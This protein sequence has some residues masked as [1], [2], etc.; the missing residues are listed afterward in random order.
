MD[1]VSLPSQG[2]T[3][4]LGRPPP[5]SRS[6]AAPHGGLVSPSSNSEGTFIPEY[7]AGLNL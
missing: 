5:R 1:C 3:V 7:P 4:A 2:R 6:R